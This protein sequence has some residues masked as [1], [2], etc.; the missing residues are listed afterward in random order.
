MVLPSPS[1]LTYLDCGVTFTGDEY[2][3]HCR[4]LTEAEKL[5]PAYLKKMEK[6]KQGKWKGWKE[7]VKT[8]LKT[9]KDVAEIRKLAFD[10]YIRL[11]CPEE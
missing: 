7:T 5:Y 2:K 11:S 3:A 9:T 10:E 6:E 1:P 4:C 8:A